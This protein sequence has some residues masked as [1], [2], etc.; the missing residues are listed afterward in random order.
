M[1]QKILRMPSLK[2]ASGYS[3]STIYLRISQ[4]TWTR[5]VSL[6]ARAVGWPESDVIALNAARISGKSDME[7]RALVCELEALR[8]APEVKGHSAL[9]SEPAPGLSRLG[10]T[11]EDP[12]HPASIAEEGGVR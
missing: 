4:G 2:E 12:R 6:G 8:L 7:I 9:N 11:I 3:R 5:P 10:Q 1:L